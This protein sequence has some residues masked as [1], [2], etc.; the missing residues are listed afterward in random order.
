MSLAMTD[1]V[2][3]KDAPAAL[4]AFNAGAEFVIYN[5]D[6]RDMLS[7]LP[8]GGVDALLSSPPY[9]M[10]KSYDRSYSV[11][12][13]YADMGAIAPDCVRVISKGGALCWQVG[14]H[15]LD[16]VVLPLDYAVFDLFRDFTD[17]TLRNRIVWHFG[18]GTHA[19]RRFSGRHE[20]ILWY[21]KGDDYYFDLDAVRVS[22]K[23]PG[24]R[25]YKGPNKG[26][27]SGN[28]LGKNPSDIWE[29]PNVKSHHIEKSGHPCQ[30]PI[31]LAQRLIRAL[32]PF[33][34]TVL[35][36]F[37]GSGSCGLA[38]VIDGRRYIGCDTSL[39][40][41][42]LAEERYFKL[43][44]GDLGY[45]PIERSVYTPDPNSAVA[46]RPDHFATFIEVD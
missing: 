6:C 23:Y 44:N 43:K 26:E 19:R 9:F 37:S 33:G 7:A 11:A 38:A 22:Q 5:G 4:K 14:M 40:Y 32:T 46:K 36:P 28:P 16:G 27:F 13:F 10:G 25:H 3:Y 24:K 2:I 20:T 45:R 1:G 15:C 17:L 42:E 30:F 34:A 29:I 35:D 39:Q 31:A 41:C 18:H 12:D 8:D 21:S